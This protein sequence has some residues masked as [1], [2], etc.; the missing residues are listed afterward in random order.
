MLQSPPIFQ[1][2]RDLIDELTGIKADNKTDCH[3]SAVEDVMM[4]KEEILK[5]WTE[6]TKDLYCDGRQYPNHT[7]AAKVIHITK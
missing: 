5:R 4:G 7:Q 3:K 2:T 6:Y 1:E